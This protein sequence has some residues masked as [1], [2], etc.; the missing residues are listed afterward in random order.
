MSRTGKRRNRVRRRTLTGIRGLVAQRRRVQTTDSRH[1]FP[2]APNLLDRNFS[3]TT[4]PNAVWLADLTDIATS[5]GWLYRAAIMDLH[6]RKIVGWS[7]RDYLR[8]ELATSALLMAIQR[9]RP[10]AGLVHHSDRGVQYA[11]SDY[12]TALSQVGITASMSRRANPLDNAPMESFFHTLKTELVHH[13]TYATRD[14][15]K[16]DVFS[17]V[18]G[19]YNRQRLHSALDYRTPDQAEQ[20]AENVA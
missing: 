17:Y 20:Q 7:M 5:E 2:I 3:A 10:E 8:A 13:R 18:E 9:Q 11:C 6:T 19:F 1:P 12:Q 16:P 4:K 15:A 14:E